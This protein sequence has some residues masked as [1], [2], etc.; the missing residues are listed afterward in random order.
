MDNYEKRFAAG[1]L[2]VIQRK[3]RTA[4]LQIHFTQPTTKP[5]LPN[6]W[7]REVSNLLS[8]LVFD[9]LVTNKKILFV[10]DTSTVDFGKVIGKTFFPNKKT[11]CRCVFPNRLSEPMWIEEKYLEVANKDTDT[12]ELYRHLLA[13]F[14]TT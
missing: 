3:Y 11:F 10:T 4:S 7:Y 14:K 6:L 8:S 5:K 1:S 9:D 2:V 12:Q 13:K